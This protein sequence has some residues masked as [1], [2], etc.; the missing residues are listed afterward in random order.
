MWKLGPLTLEPGRPHVALA[1]R[2]GVSRREAEEAFDSGVHL[3]E[4]RIDQFRGLDAD[5]VLEELEAYQAFPILATIR[6]RNEG[7]AWPESEAA[8]LE[9]FQR[10]IPHV[11]GVDIELGATEIRDAVI[12]E[13]KQAG[14]PVVVSHHDFESTP[15]LERLREIAAQAR[16]AGADLVKVA[17]QC[18]DSASLR[19][20]AAFLIEEAERGAIVIGMGETGLVSRIA[21]PALGSLVT[22]TF[23]GQPTAPGQLTCAETIQ[24]LSRL[25]EG[26]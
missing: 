26:A 24:Y 8:R 17:A 11:H 21:F 14:V 16:G 13:A 6:T 23:L 22:Y 19:R 20:L 3:V 7:G 18:N 25:Y 4:L 5:K 9:M 10:V 12:A 15:S 2:D 1:L